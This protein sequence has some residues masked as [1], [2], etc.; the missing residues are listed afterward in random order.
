MCNNS[1]WHFYMV[2]YLKY[3]IIIVTPHYHHCS[4][5]HIRLSLRPCLSN[6]QHN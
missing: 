4:R 5:D 6:I 2:G 3:Y 1:M